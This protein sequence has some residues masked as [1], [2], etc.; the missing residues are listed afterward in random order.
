MKNASDASTV[1][2][3]SST[4]ATQQS[5]ERLGLRTSTGISAFLLVGGL[6][7][8]AKNLAIAYRYGSGGGTDAFF[9]A[10]VLPA[11]FAMFWVS[12]CQVGLVP[13][14][15][16]WARDAE[17]QIE[18]R[19]SAVLAV[20]GMLTLGLTGTAYVAAPGLM[21]LIVPGF[22]EGHKLQAVRMFR[23]LAPLFALVGI[24]GVLS[25]FLNSRRSFLLPAAQKLC[26]NVVVLVGLVIWYFRAQIERLPSLIVLG[27]L[28]YACILIAETWGVA[29]Q[30]V[31]RLSKA[32]IRALLAAVLIPFVTLIARQTSQ[33]AERAI[34]SYL[35]AGSIS[36]LTY[37]FQLVGGGGAVIVAGVTT[38]L[39]PSLAQQ[40]SPWMKLEMVRQGFYYLT[41]V[42]LPVVFGGYV[43]AGPV[44]MILFQHG[45]FT[46]ADA[47]ATARMFQAYVFGM[48][49]AGMAMLFQAPFWAD[50]KYRVLVI[51]NSLIAVANVAFDLALVPFLGA[52]ALAL[53]YTLAALLSSL[54]MAW[55]LSKNY[56]TVLPKDKL[57]TVLKPVLISL[58]MAVVVFAVRKPISAAVFWQA[59]PLRQEFL[60][61]TF[62]AAVGAATYMV[63]G[64]VAGMQ[65]FPNLCTGFRNLLLR[66]SQQR[67][68]FQRGRK[69][70]AQ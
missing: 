36:A 44:V 15:A 42:L 70:S 57:G 8:V 19:M 29:F 49:F 18:K 63:G 13:L 11:T 20:S 27:S 53:G 23:G 14:L 69:D 60:A 9:A 47:S 39:M 17:G 33:V 24:T 40:K 45:A 58:I 32:E 5:K 28:A 61:T 7:E 1:E 46:A 3:I 56:G 51:H 41:V 22:S 66:N 54:R 10:F 64:V 37:A 65:P 2:V 48:I 38:S 26:V 43:L 55:L 12:S 50:R 35:P 25:A 67:T 6:L 30:S 52:T 34:A 4:F 62:I 68:T 31:Q 59:K 21:N 16:L